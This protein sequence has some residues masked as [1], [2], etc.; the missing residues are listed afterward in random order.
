MLSKK[1]TCAFSLLTCLSLLANTGQSGERVGDFALID[2]T[3]AFQHMVP[4]AVGGRRAARFERDALIAKGLKHWKISE[5][6]KI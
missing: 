3:G 1:L 4:S 2:H 6:G 5:K